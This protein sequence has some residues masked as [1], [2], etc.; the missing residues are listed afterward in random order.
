MVKGF[1]YKPFEADKTSYQNDDPHEHRDRYYDNN[2]G[3]C[4]EKYNRNE[5][6]RATEQH[7]YQ[8]RLLQLFTELLKS[9]L[10]GGN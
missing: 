8:C 4:K 2:G 5:V 9:L 7:Q 6:E 3:F 10:G 1:E